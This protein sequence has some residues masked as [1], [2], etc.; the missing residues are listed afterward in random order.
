MQ[1]SIQL[2]CSLVHLPGYGVSQLLS[3]I[4]LHVLRQPLESGTLRLSPQLPQQLLSMCVS[5]LTV[6][7]D[8]LQQRGVLLYSA[9]WVGLM[10]EV[11]GMAGVITCL[12]WAYTADGE[13]A[14]ALH[15]AIALFG[16]TE[17]REQRRG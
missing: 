1:C 9:V 7:A 3:S 13:L 4:H 17:G 11:T 10:V 5:V 12:H 8:V 15:H 2:D 6:A 14:S 16:C